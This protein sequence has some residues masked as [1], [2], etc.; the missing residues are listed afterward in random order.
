M[1]PAVAPAVAPAPVVAAPAAAVAPAVAPAV[2]TAP[3]HEAAAPAKATQD[4]KATKK[5]SKK[6]SKKKPTAHKAASATWTTRKQNGSLGAIC[7]VGKERTAIA[8]F[9]Q[10]SGQRQLH[11]QAMPR[12][13]KALRPASR[14]AWPRIARV[15]WLRRS[16]SCGLRRRSAR[17]RPRS[18]GN[19]LGVTAHA[20]TG[21]AAESSAGSWRGCRP[22]PPGAGIDAEIQPRRRQQLGDRG[23]AAHRAFHQAV[24]ELGVEGVLRREP[25]LEAV[26]M[27]ALEVEDL[28]GAVNYRRPLRRAPSSDCQSSVHAPERTFV[29]PQY[30]GQRLGVGHRAVAAPAAVACPRAWRTGDVEELAMVQLAAAPT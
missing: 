15:P 9:L 17:R 1:K 14:V 19:H 12:R 16:A 10:C 24:G 22:R 25:P 30:A 7:F 27:G 3:A 20:A 29:Q 13:P 8:R 28:H 2:A 5:Q 21:P 4:K 23:V 6:T 11:E 26:A 18:P